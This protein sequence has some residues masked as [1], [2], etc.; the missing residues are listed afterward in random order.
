MFF[1]NV[2]ARDYNLDES[3]ITVQ[4]EEKV[5]SF[6]DAVCADIEERCGEKFTPVYP[7]VA[8]TGK[9]RVYKLEGQKYS[10][11]FKLF[12]NEHFVLR[13]NGENYKKEHEFYYKIA[14]EKFSPNFLKH[15]TNSKVPNLN[16]PV[17]AYRSNDF[18]GN[19]SKFNNLCT[20]KNIFEN[21]F[22]LKESKAASLIYDI[23]NCL[24]YLHEKGYVHNDFLPEGNAML[25]N[26]DGNV[27]CFII[28]AGNIT[29]VSPGLKVFH[30]EAGYYD[31]EIVG[32]NRDFDGK[33]EV[34]SVGVVLWQLLYGDCPFAGYNFFAKHYSKLL[35]F[36]DEN[37]GQD[38]V[39]QNYLIYKMFKAMHRYTKAIKTLPEHLEKMK[40]DTNLYKNCRDLLYKLLNPDKN[41]RISAKEALNHP[42]FENKEQL[43]YKDIESL[44]GNSV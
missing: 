1:S 8:N 6:L 11:C 20:F 18:F 30:Y 28:D 42:F 17:I 34:F 4:C 44:I 9:S 39:T 36:K 29:S 14:G 35:R 23:L 33:A 41:E 31:P 15:I 43:I 24:S 25:H 26:E 13:G 32:G 19:I 22:K 38:R 40:S 7:N 10:L 3:V 37:K 27:T 5:E 2:S 21:K 12:I 16:F